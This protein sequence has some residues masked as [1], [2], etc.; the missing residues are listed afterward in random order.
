MAR[1]RPRARLILLLLATTGGIGLGPVA[2]G[3]EPP[4]PL[5]RD[6]TFRPTVIVLRGKSQGSGTIVASVPGETLV[7]TA[8]HVI[9]SDE[10]TFVEFHRQNLGI[11]RRGSAE[12]W[13]KKIAAQVVARDRATDLAVLR[14]GGL[15]AM[16]FVAR[17]DLGEGE[18]K[19]G[20][21]VVSIGIDRGT[22]F[23]SWGTRIVDVA[24]V[25]IK[26]GGGA[27]QFLLTEKSPEH[28]RSGG[29]LFLTDGTIVGVCT[30]RAE[31]V[32]GRRIGVFASSQSIRN[33]FRQND[34]EAAVAR[35]ASQRSG[36]STAAERGSKPPPAPPVAGPP[37]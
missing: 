9:E 30:G 35:S 26:R 21:V 6:L 7:L 24:R 18:P 17:V 20:T 4:K 34:L 37:R 16:P 5:S 14:V 1:G 29:P 25:D 13:P 8:A 19:P 28:G 15:G 31:V 33:I 10:Q 32:N 22:N 36:L 27:R 23:A 12:G 11:E 3:D 2:S